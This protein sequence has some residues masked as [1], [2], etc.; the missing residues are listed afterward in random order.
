MKADVKVTKGDTEK[1]PKDR[2]ID[3]A[4]RLFCRQGINAT[5]IDAVL[6]EAGTAKMTL[7]NLF[8]SKDRLVEAVLEEEG[9]KWRDWF[10]TAL[11]AGSDPPR[12]KLDRIFP[13]LRGWFEAEEFYGCPFINAVG[14]HDKQDDRLRALTMRHKKE[15]LHRFSALA[16]AAGAVDPET[17]AHQLGLLMDGTIVAVMVTRD[18][19]LADVAAAAASALLDHAT[20]D[21]ATAAEPA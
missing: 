21:H 2:L 17:V 8:G 20:L 6:K 16:A 14:E 9:R 12:R 15:V 7:Y 11:D 4:S 18:L 1:P 13:L 3:A 5:G 19:A 10:L